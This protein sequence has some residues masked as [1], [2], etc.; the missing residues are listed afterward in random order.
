[1]IK[2]IL[3]QNFQTIR[4]VKIEQELFEFGDRK[5]HEGIQNL[6]LNRLKIKTNAQ[7]TNWQESG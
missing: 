3:R 7:Q 2:E 1:M 6:T 4:I 5:R